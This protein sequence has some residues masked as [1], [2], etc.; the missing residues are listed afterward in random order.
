MDS[1][2]GIL[3]VDPGAELVRRDVQ[4]PDQLITMAKAL[5]E[6][7]KPAESEA[8]F[9]RL[10]GVNGQESLGFYGIGM[11]RMALG[12]RSQAAAFFQR[13][14]DHDPANANALYQLGAIAERGGDAE[15]ARDYFER[16]LR[17]SPSHVSARQRLEALAPRPAPQPVQPLSAPPTPT[18]EV[19]QTFAGMGGSAIY[20][21]LRQ[22]QN[23]LSRQTIAALDALQ[24]RVRP[25]LTAYVGRH[26][27]R[28]LLFAVLTLGLSAVYG[29]VRVR[30]MTVAFD[31]GRLQIQK[32][33]LSR[34]L[35][36]IDLWRVRGVELD[37]TFVNRVTGD[38]ALVLELI[39]QAGSSRRSKND[40]PLKL[41]GV[42]RGQRLDDLYP[43]LLNTVF[44]LRSNPLVKGIIQ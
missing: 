30:S 17:V 36:N 13:A 39:P 7:G 10:T 33:I 32:G 43:Q 37:R 5:L 23:P 42:A 6:Q 38:G 41:I 44:L 14:L 27:I 22:D 11:T 35:M 9:R 28:S 3:V 31:N 8:L 34:H 18:A 15:Q 25:R 29:F 24:M 4:T 20:D 1:S 2:N 19:A 21:F 26:L 16:A 40:K 12:E